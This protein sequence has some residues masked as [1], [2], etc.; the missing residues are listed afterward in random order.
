[1]LAPDNTAHS[2]LIFGGGFIANQIKDVLTAQGKAT[3]MSKARIESREEV[4]S[5]LVR[6]KPTRVI[7]CAGVRGLHNADWCEDHKVETMRSNVLGALNV[8]DVCFQLGIHITHIGSA[9]IYTVEGDETAGDRSPFTETDEPFFQGCWYGRSRLLSELSIRHYP[10]LLLLRVRIPISADLHP[11]NHVTKLL[12]YEKI[13]DLTGSGTVLPN[14]IPAAIILLDHGETGTYNWVTPG[15]I[16]NVEIMELAKKT[17]RPDLKWQIFKVEDMLAKLKAPRAICIMDS[18]KLEKKCLEYGYRIK[19]RREALEE[20][21]QI[22]A[23]NQEHCQIST[24]HLRWSV[25]LGS[26]DVTLVATTIIMHLSSLV[27]AM[28]AISGM[29]TAS[30]IPS[31][32]LE[33]R[34]SS[35]AAGVVYSKCS[36]PGVFALTFDDGPG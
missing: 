22:M 21:F 36:K 26:Y 33:P 16:S 10:N 18:S 15:E 1:M 34:Q 24:S 5:E 2:Y 27:P 23:E 32:F 30:T 29:A 9:C 17:I 14:L 25:N 12:K 13:V 3:I 11:K 8:V 19:P 28:L 35:P 7:N 31:P 20:V 6:H 4:L